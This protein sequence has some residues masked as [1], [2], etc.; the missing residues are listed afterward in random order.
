[1]NLTRSV[2][3]FTF[4]LS[5]G[6]EALLPPSPQNRTYKFPSI[7]LKQ[8][9]MAMLSPDGFVGG[10]KDVPIGSWVCIFSPALGVL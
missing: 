9:T 2:T 10:R 5:G 4:L 3:A 6:A 1:M 7:R 8:V